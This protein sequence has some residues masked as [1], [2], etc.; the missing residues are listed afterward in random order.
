[1]TSETK[2]AGTGAKI[3]KQVAAVAFGAIFLWLAFSKADFNQIWSYAK[4]ANPI[5]L[6]LVCVSGVI[7]HLLR[8]ARW[9]IMLRP[10]TDRKISLWNSFCAVIYGY[11][12]NLAYKAPT[13]FGSD[14]LQNALLP[15]CRKLLASVVRQVTV[16][17]G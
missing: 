1:M 17:Q 11:A 2:P 13:Q 3:A 16:N 15:I 8:A 7:S 6:L 10:L 4:Q 5:F 14:I 12:V 9:L